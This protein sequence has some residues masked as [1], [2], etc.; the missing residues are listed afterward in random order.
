MRLKG[1]RYI[2]VAAWVSII[3]F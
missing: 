1:S 3:R 2:L